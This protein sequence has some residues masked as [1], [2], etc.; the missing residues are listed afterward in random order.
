MGKIKKAII[1]DIFR[2]EIKNWSKFIDFIENALKEVFVLTNNSID[3]EGNIISDTALKDKIAVELGA[4][5]G[6]LSIYLALRGFRT[7]CTDLTNPYDRAKKNH[8][9]YSIEKVVEYQAI[10]ITKNS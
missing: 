9:K 4:D 5:E 8:I 1:K 3:D 7:K 6:G 2:W 10:D